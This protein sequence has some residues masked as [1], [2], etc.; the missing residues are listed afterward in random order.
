M[1]GRRTFLCLRIGL[2][3][4]ASTG[5]MSALYGGADRVGSALETDAVWRKAIGNKWLSHAFDLASY[6]LELSG[7]GT[8][9][10][11]NPA[12]RLTLEFNGREAWLMHPGDSVNF[13]L[14]GYGYG[15]RLSEPA[16]AT[17]SGTG[18]RV[19]V[20]AREISPNGT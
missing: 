18:N 3:S 14:T 5:A 6:S 8:W 20:P 13:H 15:D 10:G 17:L 9:R 7:E 2:A 11:A 4:L 19:G 12:Q 1:P 16:R